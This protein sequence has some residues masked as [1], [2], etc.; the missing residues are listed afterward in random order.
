M[1]NYLIAENYKF[2]KSRGWKY[3]ILISTIISLFII[4]SLPKTINWIDVL[5]KRNTEI[6]LKLTSTQLE[7]STSTV[8]VSEWR[9]NNAYL[10]NNIKPPLENTMQG[11]LSKLLSLR[12]LGLILIV[13]T[14]LF[15][16][17]LSKEFESGSI[18]FMLISPHKRN[19][20]ILGKYFSIILNSFLFLTLIFLINY[21]FAYLFLEKS[22]DVYFKYE[23]GILS[24][25]NILFFVIKNSI[26][27]LFY[28][29]SYITLAF[30][31]SVIFK[32]TSETLSITLILA[33]L[34]TQ[35]VQMFNIVG[36]IKYLILPTIV[37]LTYY[38]GNKEFFNKQLLVFAIFMNLVYISFFLL[39][40]I[41]SFTKSDI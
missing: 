34:G 8:L 4:N 14:I 38:S 41:K 30:M 36:N 21:I 16:S 18:K 1:R 20:I 35:I 37:D 23:N 9:E 27:A 11:Y 29:L 10:T 2:F 28:Y 39:I 19:I 33:L 31:L 40:S 17:T 15:A 25:Y 32:G 5:T 6:E 7:D 26:L 13:F 22:G 3:A 24:E 12:G